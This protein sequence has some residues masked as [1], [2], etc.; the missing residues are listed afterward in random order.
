MAPIN[1]PDGSQVSEIVLPDGSTASEVLAPDGST[2]FSAIPDSA[3]A[4]LN[5]KQLSGFSDGDTITNRPDQ[6]GNLSD[7]TGEG[8]YRPSAANGFASVEYDGSNDGHT[9]D[10]G[11]TVNQKLVVISVI[12]QP[13]DNGNDHMIAASASQSNVD[14]Q[15]DDSSVNDFVA[16]A[17]SLTQSG[18]FPTGNLDVATVI[19]DDVN[20]GSK[21]RLNGSDIETGGGY[22]TND[23]T[24]LSVG[25]NPINGGK[26]TGQIPFV[27]VHDGDVDGGL[28]DR[29]SE[30]ANKFG[31]SI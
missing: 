19:F 28:Q 30:V 31:L 26:F 24:L 13:V 21:M 16:D 2:V 11:Q 5:A 20:N 6:T 10:S 4:Q 9:I 22:G 8:T 14:F 15:V 17:G 12:E 29:E 27:E 7:L 23:M 1:L 25:E 3:V 18:T